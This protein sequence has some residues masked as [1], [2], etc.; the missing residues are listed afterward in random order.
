MGYAAIGLIFISMSA[1][2]A[3]R[4]IHNARAGLTFGITD[5]SGRGVA[6]PESRK[7]NPIGFWLM[8]ASQLAGA[9][10]GLLIGV[11]VTWTALSR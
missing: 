7:T 4:V 3:W 6:F 1:V 11:L 5:A 2:A 10:G 8:L 9:L